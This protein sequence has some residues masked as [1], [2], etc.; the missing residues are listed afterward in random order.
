M[1]YILPDGRIIDTSR[2]ESISSVRDLG[3]DTKTID[4]NR[5]GFTI[6][7][8]N[9][10]IVDIREYY[11]YSDWALVKTRMNRLHADLRQKWQEEDNK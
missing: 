6:H 11:Q 10:E 8:S 9:R 4:R 7:L 3:R 5:M 2:I 1:N